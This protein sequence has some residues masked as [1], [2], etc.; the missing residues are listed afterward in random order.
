MT[1]GART[2]LAA[3]ARS[4]R[5]TGTAAAA[6]A[7]RYCARALE[8]AG[9]RVTERPFEYSAFP[10]RVAT[11]AA[12]VWGGVTIAASAIL[13]GA[14]VP[15][16]AAM[17]LAV[18][19]VLLAVFSL[20]MAR[21][22]VLDFPAM[23]VGGVNLECVRGHDE[24]RVWLV[25]HVDSKSQGVPMI[26]R[27]AGVIGLA[28]VWLAALVLAALGAIGGPH[29][30]PIVWAVIGA[31]GVCAAIPVALTL[32]GERSP[33]AV[34]NASGVAA[35]LAAA[36]QLPADAP[37]GVLVTD[38]EEL[39]L[40]GA[41]AWVRGRS[42]GTAINCD[43]VD[44]TGTLR[45]MYSGAR[46]HRVIAALSRAADPET[47]DARRLLAGVLVDGVAFA[48]AGWEVATAMRGNAATLRRVHRPSDDLAHLRGDALD[49]MARLL[50][51]AALDL[52]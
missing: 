15:G 14:G 39:G 31:A 44:D 46:P 19:A 24:P 9:F 51:A 28:L 13:G 16:I 50:A 21:H 30:G 22:G 17:L 2:H 27:V 4:A 42:P 26:G 1:V 49:G 33:G 18:S 52:C 12:G 20:W 35:V 25:A 43:G 40:A 48:E 5:P 34:D 29:L 8:D 3:L 37:V 6:E 11:P 36:A 47:V 7:R 32:V 23:R 10:G 45:A 38:A 41:R